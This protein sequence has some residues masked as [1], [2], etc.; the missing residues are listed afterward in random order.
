MEVEKTKDNKLSQGSSFFLTLGVLVIL[1]LMF[2]FALPGP[3]DRKYPERIPVR[4]WHQWTAEWKEVVEG[5]VDEFNESQIKY[6]V[7]PLSVPGDQSDA[8]FLLALTGG[9]PPEVICANKQVIPTW[10]DSDMLTPLNELMGPVEWEEYRN[11]VYPV[12]L[13][14]TMHKG[15]LYGS[16]AGIDVWACYYRADHFRE[17]GL[18]PDR[19]PETIEEFEKCV[20]KLHRFDSEGNLVR[21]GFMPPEL[22]LKF[23]PSF[24]GSFY[25]WESGQLIINSTGNLAGL[26]FLA[27]YRKNLGFDNVLR[28]ESGQIKG[29]QSGA[30]E[31][32][33]ITGAYSISLEGEWKVEQLRKYAP[34]VDYRTAP[35]P[36]LTEKNQLAMLAMGTILVIPKDASQ[37]EGGW[38]FVKFWTGFDDPERTGRFVVA[39]GTLPTNTIVSRSKVFQKY[40]EENPA[41]KTFDRLL[42]SKNLQPNP[43]VAFNVFLHDR[44]DMIHDVAVKKGELSPREALDRLEWEISTE[45]ARREKL[46]YE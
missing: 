30:G 28:F 38:E 19:F 25:D 33:F 34:H 40:L 29:W 5:I 41:M 14:L 2:T 13:Q 22:L 43:P 27:D 9:D 1:G 31:W 35:L 23:V 4:F 3:R 11:T 46:G 18:D 42:P 20:E 12:V 15:N 36:G 16:M 6:E 39:L 8:K 32:P 44:L 17:A 7:I 45:I 21:L 24:G 26:S 37:I 10:A